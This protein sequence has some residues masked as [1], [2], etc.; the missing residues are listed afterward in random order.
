MVDIG[1]ERIAVD[2]LVEHHGRHHAGEAQACDGWSSSNGYPAASSPSPFGVHPLWRSML[3]EAQVSP[4][5]K[6]APDREPK[7]SQV[8]RIN[9]YARSPRLALVN[10]SPGIQVRAPMAYD[11]PLQQSNSFDFP[12]RITREPQAVTYSHSPE[13]GQER[14]YCEIRVGLTTGIRGNAPHNP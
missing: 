11:P 1:L 3:V 4:I 10:R 14:T 13:S 6:G 12:R 9:K 7:P 5:K 8:K 2:R